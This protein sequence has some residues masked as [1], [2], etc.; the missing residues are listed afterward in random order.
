[1]PVYEVEGFGRESGRPRTRRY[2][3]N[4]EDEAINAASTDGTVVGDI[5][6]LQDDTSLAGVVGR[7]PPAPRPPFIR[8]YRTHVAGV[9][10]RTRDGTSRQEL[11]QDLWP[12][13]VLSLRREPS[14]K[15]DPNAVAVYSERDEHIGYIPAYKAEWVAKHLD[16]G[17]REW[18]AV[19]YVGSFEDQKFREKWFVRIM[20]ILYDPS[21]GEPEVQAYVNEHKITLGVE[22]PTDSQ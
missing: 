12:G 10:K 5:R 15:H 16:S 4:T 13:D 11:V 19:D 9:T 3:G 18:T 2:W 14:N 17:K 6:R 22:H 21:L 1:M 8:H 7:P 20:F